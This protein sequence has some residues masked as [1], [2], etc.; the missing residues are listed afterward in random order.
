[1]S[2]INFGTLAASAQYFLGLFDLS[3]LP[4]YATWIQ[5][6]RNYRIKKVSYKFVPR[7]IETGTGGFSTQAG[8]GWLAPFKT[9]NTQ[10]TNDTN[11]INLPGCKKWDMRKPAFI[12]I[13]PV[14]MNPVLESGTTLYAYK[15]A[16]AP[17]LDVSVTTF[18]HWGICGKMP[19]TGA[20]N[21]M[22]CD[23]I[24]TYHVQFKNRL[25]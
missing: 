17:W 13:T 22:K 23:A 1:V 15:P 2:A 19:M 20:D 24:I 8:L 4:G 11:L 6:Y 12:S 14:V 21:D 9:N 18:N 25:I 10:P 3:R 5:L 7:G 16:K